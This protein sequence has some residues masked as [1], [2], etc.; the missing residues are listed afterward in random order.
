MKEPRK[1]T[2][3]LS[4]P[5]KEAMKL[6]KNATAEVKVQ[7]PDRDQL[8][9]AVEEGLCR[10]IGVKSKVLVYRILGQMEAMQNWGSS[11]VPPGE[12]L[13]FAIEMM[14]GLRPTNATEA[15]L[16]VQMVG[17]HNAAI[18]FLA[19]ATSTDQTADGSDANVLRATRLMRIFNEQLKAM[20]KLRG[21]T[22]QQKVVVEHVH[23]HSGGQA[24]VGT[25]MSPKKVPEERER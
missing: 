2:A 4:A 1:G 3:G 9:A 18:Q 13:M 10:M 25:V 23:V 6:P 19:N 7:K 22:S 21:K 5:A 14:A 12:R 17:V 24:V 8:A 15:L 11:H 20:Q 16:A